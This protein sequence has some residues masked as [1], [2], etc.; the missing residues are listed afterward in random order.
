L[1]TKI[2]NHKQKSFSK[3]K[4]N[5]LKK[6]G[7]IKHN[8]GPKRHLFCIQSGCPAMLGAVLNLYR[9]DNFDN[10]FDVYCNE[11]SGVIAIVIPMCANAKFRFILVKRALEKAV[12]Q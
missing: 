12:L 6:K 4:T 3:I 5:S 10:Y 2:R 1:R 11:N 7:Q 8:H 9:F